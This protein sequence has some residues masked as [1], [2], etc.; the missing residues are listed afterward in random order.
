MK[1]AFVMASVAYLALSAT[2]VAAQNAPAAQARS[3][4][5]ETQADVVEILVTAQRRTE[6]LQD[7]P[8]SVVAVTGESLE[9]RNIQDIRQLYLAAPSLQ[10]SGGNDRDSAF[11]IR[12]VGTL[13][14]VPTVENS[15][16]VAVDDINLGRA[17]LAFGA[18]DDVAR[19]EALS[20][21]QGLL[22]G[23]NASAGLLHIITNRPRLGEFE[24]KIDGEVAYRDTVGHSS[25][26]ELIR[27]VVNLPIGTSSALRISGRYVHQD[28]LVRSIRPQNGTGNTENYG[29][30]VKFL[31]EPSDNF[32]VYLI[33]EYGKRSGLPLA[34]YR[35]AAP[36]GEITPVLV[37]N[38][39]VPGQRNFVGGT[40]GATFSDDEMY[41][42]QGT[43]TLTLP[44]DWELITVLG[45]KK[46]ETVA[47]LDTDRT[48][49][50][51]LSLSTADDTYSQFSGELRLA[52]PATSR[53]NGQLGIY[54]YK[55]NAD[56]QRNL[57][58]LQGRTPAAA[59]N[60]P[61]CVGAQPPFGG[62]PRCARSNDFVNGR[63]V[64]SEYSNESYAAFGQ[65]NF[66]LTE[67]LTLI[68]GMRVTHDKVS[69]DNVQQQLNYFINLAD[70]GVFSGR[71]TNT[72]FSYKIGAQ[73]D[74]NDDIMAYGYF[75]TGYKGPGFNDVF[76]AGVIPQVDD[77]TT[78][79]FEVGIKSSWLDGAVI[80]NISAFLQKFYDY[81]AQAFV[82]E[83]QTFELRNAAEL[84]S[85]GIE[86]QISLRPVRGL[87][88]NA[89]ATILDAKYARFP[90][91][92]CAPG[93]V[94]CAANG[95]FDASG[96][97]LPGSAEFSSTVQA[98]YSFELSDDVSAFVDA[99]WY[100]RS[101]INFEL[102][103]PKLT[104][105][106]TVDQI[107]ASIGLETNNIRFSFF[108]RNCFDQVRPSLVRLWA[109]D[110]RNRLPTAFQTFD[111]NSVRNIGIVA[112][113]TF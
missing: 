19:V 21:P 54:Y 79:A 15:V 66:D 23:K 28:S 16:A 74:V 85:K 113:Y 59:R 13:A 91:A 71:A 20:G 72:N 89:N 75:S 2:H 32:E 37:A 110:A 111:L 61:F 88:V 68:G 83:R 17:N 86:A 1:R 3:E 34:S 103:S 109:G 7:V 24:G 40:D 9:A 36:T 50:D 6:S 46:L 62:P 98:R 87:T 65:L 57:G 22:F 92:Q 105:I 106:G 52:L 96:L 101:P 10:L 12:G 95:T 70:R 73:Y 42:I 8:V 30:R 77:E 94:P 108:C 104:E 90:G 97:Q 63:D 48:V 35:Q 38:G 53:I 60:F 11:Y 39:I 31:T 4:T 80:V 44:N 112:S 100:H 26:G 69:I 33:G 81:Q 93:Q 82:I 56:M 29:F 14:L 84:E 27:G 78:D 41:G 25:F 47:N 107:G 99:N 67:S 76:A 102:V 43:A 58:G 55:S 64:F 5:D 18:F 45:Y 49:N 51:F